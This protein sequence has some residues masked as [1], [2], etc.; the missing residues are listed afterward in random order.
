MYQGAIQAAV[1]DLGSVEEIRD[2]F[3]GFQRFLDESV[4]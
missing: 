3:N 2:V 1:A 4:G